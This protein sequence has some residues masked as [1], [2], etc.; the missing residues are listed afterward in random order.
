MSLCHG[1]KT[2]LNYR[3]TL[4]TVLRIY[5]QFFIPAVPDI[6]GTGTG[7]ISW[8]TWGAGERGLP[9]AEAQAGSAGSPT[10]CCPSA[11][12]RGEGRG[13]D[14]TPVPI[15]GSGL[16]TPALHHRRATC[17]H[18]ICAPYLQLKIWLLERLSFML[19]NLCIS[20]NPYFFK[21]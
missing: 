19:L 10:R 15:P 14:R 21:N 5:L 1:W 9:R 11:L 12:G 2:A 6:S 13:G 20:G 4:A 3:V 17:F 18:Q 8:S 7:F 16:G